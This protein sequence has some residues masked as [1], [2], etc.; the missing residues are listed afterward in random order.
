MGIVQEEWCFFN[1]KE[2]H[3]VYSYA[4]CMFYSAYVLSSAVQRDS[5]KTKWLKYRLLDNYYIVALMWRHLFWGRAE[6]V[7]WD[8]KFSMN[9]GTALG[10]GTQLEVAT[11]LP[12]REA[13]PP[14]GWGISWCFPSAGQ[15]GEA[16][17]PNSDFGAFPVKLDGSRTYC[18]QF[19]DSTW[20][21]Y[22]HI[23]DAVCNILVFGKNFMI[24]REKI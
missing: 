22:H 2:Q 19:T 15:Y 20:E 3:V 10:L 11:C 21:W 13:R 18:P 5:Q 6:K 4:Y 1:K 8:I 7:A 17:L 14:L 12:S 9:H 16:P 24:L 23:R